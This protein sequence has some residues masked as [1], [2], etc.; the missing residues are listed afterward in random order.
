[1]LWSNKQT[2]MF[3]RIKC[4]AFDIQFV[5]FAL[6]LGCKIATAN[7]SETINNYCNVESQTKHVYVINPLQ[8]MLLSDNLMNTILMLI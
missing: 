4:L 5:T 8:Q 7:C 6:L 1:M 2:N 3:A